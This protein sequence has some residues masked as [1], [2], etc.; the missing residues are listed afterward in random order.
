MCGRFGLFASGEE[1]TERYP[2]VE[3]PP[4]DPH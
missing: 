3:I 1:L 4:L 2:F